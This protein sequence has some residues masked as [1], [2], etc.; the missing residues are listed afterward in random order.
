MRV[1]VGVSGPSLSCLRSPV[2]T[3]PLDLR[4]EFGV[5]KSV[6]PAMDSMMPLDAGSG[7][8]FKFRAWSNMSMASG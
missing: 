1:S 2:P 6:S 7:L 3:V 8:L 5:P 4:D